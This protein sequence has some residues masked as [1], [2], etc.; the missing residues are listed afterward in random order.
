MIGS[1]E[2][3]HA[4]LSI[5]ADAADTYRYTFEAPPGVPVSD[6]EREPYAAR[7]TVASIDGD[8]FSP[9]TTDT[10]VRN[11]AE[12]FLRTALPS[13]IKLQLEQWATSVSPHAAVLVVAASTTEMADLPWELLSPGL[14]GRLFV[15]RMGPAASPKAPGLEQ[16]RMF[17]TGWMTLPG[18]SMLPGVA[19]ELNEIPRQIDD[20]RIEI[21]SL[22]SPSF[23]QFSS[24]IVKANPHLL[25]MAV[26]LGFDTDEARVSTLRLDPVSGASTDNSDHA[27]SVELVTDDDLIALLSDTKDLRLCVLNTQPNPPIAD[28]P[29][30]RKLSN[31]LGIAV[32][33][34]TGIC[35]DAIAADFAL[36]LYQR[37]AEGSS[38][39]EAVRSFTSRV[40]ASQWV[41]G[42]LP[43]V[44]IPSLEWVTD[45][46]LLEPEPEPTSRG[47]VAE[48]TTLETEPI[49]PRIS[50]DFRP[51]ESLFPSLLI[52]GHDP[53]RSLTITANGAFDARIEL[54]CDIGGRSSSY[55]WTQSLVRGP[56]P[57]LPKRIGFP[58][59]YELIHSREPRMVTFQASVWVDDTLVAQTTELVR[60]R[61][62]REWLDSE[63]S[64]A[65]LSS[66]VLPMSK[67]IAVLVHDAEG[68]LAQIG[69]PLQSFSGDRN[70]EVEASAVADLQMK[71]IYQALRGWSLK[72]ITPPGTP[73]YVLD[74]SDDPKKDPDLSGSSPVG[75]ER[76]SVMSGQLV[77]LPEDIVERR[78][79][80]C[81]DLALLFAA[82][83]EYVD[84]RPIL[85][86]IP[87]HTFFGFWRDKRF[88]ERFWQSDP[89]LVKGFGDTW[90]IPA[91][92]LP[93]LVEDEE[94]SVVEAT[95]VT[96]PIATYEQ[97][98]R[99]AERYVQ[100]R[101]DAAVDVR[102]SRG[103]IQPLSLG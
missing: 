58:V 35:A 81:H 62:E 27:E 82:A 15:V 98:K 25:H 31:E 74:P 7:A 10:S 97:A 72:Y 11:V 19:K 93:R 103:Y 41:T 88:Q 100:N 69:D 94:I 57:L 101:I 18:G 51:Q 49:V 1:F 14:G 38:L 85:V 61:A 44:W 54:E 22:V 28:A 33:G 4:L 8:F 5:S 70:D 20:E 67:A 36:F 96:N 29:L 60:W 12:L 40:A 50:V 83:A 16:L 65:Y 37:L 84:L 95:L 63:D 64:Y 102:R 73:V 24:E 32:V 2:P 45:P 46:V 86:L 6:A 21:L 71:A 43:T 90:M 23:G 66:F 47:A 13:A 26:A 17:V 80:T 48:P 9:D 42:G 34:W 91:E 78:H 55:N 87:G 53:I 76:R 30:Y 75:R 92:R 89:N 39:P 68:V 77:R 56:N 79:A 59:L 52:N 99:R 3:A